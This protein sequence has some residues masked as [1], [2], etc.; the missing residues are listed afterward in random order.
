MNKETLNA[1]FDLVFDRI[2][3]KAWNAVIAST[4]KERIAKFEDLQKQLRAL[5]EDVEK[6]I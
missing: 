6:L 4:K 5:R 2:E 3:Q 1:M